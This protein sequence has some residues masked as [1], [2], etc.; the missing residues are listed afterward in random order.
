V[1]ASPT[2][3]LGNPTRAADPRTGRSRDHPVAHLGAFI[4]VSAAGGMVVTYFLAV[5]TRAGQ[6]VDTQ[7]MLLTARTL[8]GAH[9]TEAV[10]SLIT[11]TTVSVGDAWFD[12][13]GML[14]LRSGYAACSPDR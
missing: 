8:A 12:P 6:V 14:V 11:P 9:W 2:R 3:S 1:I 13:E 7:A 10:L 5:Q 4:A